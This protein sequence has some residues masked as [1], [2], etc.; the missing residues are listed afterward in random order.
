[1]E[2]K[3]IAVSIKEA[4]KMLDLS[5]MTVRRMVKAGKMPAK[6]IGQ[7]WRIPVADLEKWLREGED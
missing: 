7:Q 5:E 3:K 1:M 6:K 2:P 4:A